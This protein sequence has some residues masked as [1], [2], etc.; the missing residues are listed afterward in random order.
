MTDNRLAPGTRTTFRL[1]YRSRDRVPA[2]DRED[3]LG[4]LF[5][6]SRSNNEKR[7]ITGALLLTGTWFVQVLEGE[8]AAVRSLFASIQL[9]HRH[10]RVELL[11]EGPADDRIFAHWSMAK[12]ALSDSDIPL[13]AQISEISPVS[14]RRMTPEK[15]RLFDV[16]REAVDRAPV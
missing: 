1:M 11:F 6:S 7:N 4:A 5:A 10:D 2:A 14:L 8:E 15:S 3:E 16:M 9:D 13:I 12:I